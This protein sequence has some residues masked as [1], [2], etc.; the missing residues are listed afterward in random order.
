M[1]QIDWYS[2][3][4]TARD[5][6]SR[7]WR[8]WALSGELVGVLAG[9]VK[10]AGVIPIDLLGVVSAA[11]A[12]MTAWFQAHRLDTEAAAYS[13]TAREIRHILSLLDENAEADDWAKFVDQAESAI[14]RE[15]TMWT[16]GRGGRSALTG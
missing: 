4:A 3:T 10:A 16:A 9:T 14:S 7:R 5:R 15:H 13:L 12:G 8:S 2:H 6:S 1:E 11:V